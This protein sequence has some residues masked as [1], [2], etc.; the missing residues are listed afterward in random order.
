MEARC[1]SGKHGIQRRLAKETRSDDLGKRDIRRPKSMVLDVDAKRFDAFHRYVEL[2][3]EFI[4]EGGRGT[5]IPRKHEDVSAPLPPQ[6]AV[7][8]G[9][10]SL[11]GTADVQSRFPKRCYARG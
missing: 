11:V 6:N 3:A 10:S 1:T 5:R 4:P 9:L 2:T 7:D 8:Y